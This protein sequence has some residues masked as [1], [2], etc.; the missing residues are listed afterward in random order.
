[1]D[2]THEQNFEFSPLSLSLWNCRRLV[3]DGAVGRVLNTYT[4]A[5]DRSARLFVMLH[6][7]KY[8]VYC[9]HCLIC[10][11]LCIATDFAIWFQPDWY[12]IH[13]ISTDLVSFLLL[14]MFYSIGT[15]FVYLIPSW[16]TRV[17]FDFFDCKPILFDY[18]TQMQDFKFNKTWKE[19]TSVVCFKFF[20]LNRWY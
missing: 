4:A 1:M 3:W 10:E 2:I 19:C 13:V 16:L 17:L 20:W 9:W 14:T 8:H 7:L 5:L 15:D 6:L 12:M 18:M 11:A